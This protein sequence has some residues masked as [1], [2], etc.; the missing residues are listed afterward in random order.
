MGRSVSYIRRRGHTYACK[1]DSRGR[2][3]R[4]A[5]VARPRTIFEPLTGLGEKYISLYGTAE[6]SDGIYKARV[7]AHG[8]GKDL[9]YLIKTLK[10]DYVPK[11][12]YK[13]VHGRVDRIEDNFFEYFTRGEWTDYEVE[14]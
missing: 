14:S 8:T 1:R 5:R 6:S 12:R 10:E 4:F 7:D 2:F 11:R 9:Y 3:T 13:H